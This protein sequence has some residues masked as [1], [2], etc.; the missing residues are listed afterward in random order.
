MVRLPKTRRASILGVSQ[1]A[2]RA[3][4]F[5]MLSS[6]RVNYAA[7][8]PLRNASS[9]NKLFRLLLSDLHKALGVGQKSPL[10]PI[11]TVMRLAQMSHF[12]ISMVKLWLNEGQLYR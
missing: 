1:V 7:S 9:I 11:P 2:A 10:I 8:N 3:M 6:S 5:Q 4:P 12:S